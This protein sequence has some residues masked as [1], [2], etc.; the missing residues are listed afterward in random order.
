MQRLVFS[1]RRV[2][3]TRPLAHYLNQTSLYSDD[4]FALRTPGFD[5]GQCLVGPLEREDPV[6]HWAYVTGLDQGGDLSELAAVRCHADK[7]IGDVQ[8]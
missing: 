1:A 6:H 2:G 3:G 5:I 4:D 8:D 7:R